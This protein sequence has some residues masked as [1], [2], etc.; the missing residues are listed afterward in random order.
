M[1]RLAARWLVE[2]RQNYWFWPMILTTLAVVLGI[3]VPEIDRAVGSDWTRNAGWIRA[4][5]VDG[6][7]GM[8]TTLAGSV[9][10][11]AGT[12]FSITIVAVSFASGNFG[13]RLIG[14]FMR[15]RT[16]QVILGVFLSTFAY[17]IVLLRSIHAATG[18]GGPDALAA[19]VPQIGIIVALVLM[20]VSIGSLI[21]FIHHVPE[22]INIM[23]LAA[24]VGTELRDTIVAALDEAEDGGGEGTSARHDLAPAAPS[25]DE[26]PPEHRRT[27]HAAYAGYVLRY[28]LAHMRELADEHDL[29]IRVLKR[30]GSFVVER[31][32][33]MAVWPRQALDDETED[34]LGACVTIGDE[35]TSVQDLLFLSDELVEMVGRALS[36]GVN[37]P[38]TAVTCL[39]WLRVGLAEFARRCP[40]E[41]DGRARV[42]LDRVTF[43]TMLERSFGK[44]RQYLAADRNAT[45]H[46]LDVLADLALVTD[47]PERRAH[48]MG[49]MKTLA[50]SAREL[51]S[52]QSA[53]DEVSQALAVAR[54]RVAR[55]SRSQGGPEVHKPSGKRVVTAGGV[56]AAD[57]SAALEDAQALPEG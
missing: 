36:P 38:Q 31:E 17:C 5:Q 34:A 7:R 53:R 24:Q 48:V 55:D 20:L 40:G 46:A 2:F 8:L 1:R 42:R 22:S 29:A 15:D 26:P 16:N 13:P 54:R 18:E 49:V 44:M 32:P 50:T 14:N 57:R 45:L 30:P 21:Y 37:D 47:Q 19:F 43:E 41:S 39:N 23:N 4:M 27:L 51:L 25:G 9:L 35:R 28:D 11:V 10:G 56:R 12:A 6:A 33:I 3:L 52:E